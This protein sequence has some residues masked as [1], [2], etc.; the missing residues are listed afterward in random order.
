MIPQSLGTMAAHI[1]VNT[2]QMDVGIKMATS[3]LKNFSTSI[4]KAGLTTIAIGVTLGI[5]LA[6]AIKL[7]GKFDDEMRTVSAVTGST[8]DE[9]KLLTKQA[10]LLGR[11]TSF[12]VLEV[13][14]GMVTLGRAS[15]SFDFVQEAIPNILNLA[16][17]TGTELAR[18]AEFATATLNAFK[19]EASEM[20]R[21]TDTLTATANASAQTL[22]DLGESMKFAAPVAKAFGMTMEETA[23][24]IGTLANIGVKGSMAG[25]GLRM[26]MLQLV[27]SSNRNKLMDTLGVDVIDQ[28]TGGM[29]K[30]TV[31]L[32][33]MDKAMRSQGLGQ[34]DI[35]SIMSDVFGARAVTAGLTLGTTKFEALEAAIKN[36]S[37]TTERTAKK[38]DAGLGGAL[39]R[40]WSA[41]EGARLAV[42]EGLATGVDALAKAFTKVLGPLTAFLERNQWVVQAV[43]VVTVA[44]LTVGITLLT[45]SAGAWLASAAMAG[46]ATAIKVVGVALKF[47]AANPIIL[48]IIGIVALVAAIIHFLGT[49]DTFIE[50][51]K[52]IGIA[53]H[54]FILPAINSFLKFVKRI[55]DFVAPIFWKL[56]DVAKAAWGMLREIITMA[57]T[58]V[59]FVF[60]AVSEKIVRIWNWVWNTLG[61]IVQP[62]LSFLKP[63]IIGFLDK[64]E[65]AFKEWKLLIQIAVMKMVTFVVGAFWDLIHAIK[66]IPTWLTWMKDNWRDILQTIWN[67]LKTFAKNV[68]ENLKNLG[69]SIVRLFT[70]G[71]WKFKWTDLTKGFES[72]IK[73]FPDIIKRN[74]GPIE[75]ALKDTVKGLEKEL[76]DAYLK[77]IT[78]KA[79]EH[80][81]KVMNEA[82]VPIEEE[83]EEALPGRGIGTDRGI[84]LADLAEKG[85][86]DAYSA[87]V[88]VAN[89]N[90]RVEDNTKGIWDEVKKLNMDQKTKDTSKADTVDLGLVV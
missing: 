2:A 85:T 72:T 89:P 43:G 5:G 83:A 65:F 67:G 79:N 59:V 81:K 70:S 78:K 19:L 1:A 22:S 9:L 4:R 62:V 12:T 18:S 90:K 33:E 74:V 53:I 11:T 61:A 26:V 76:A 50:K 60:S 7:F 88:K 41:A 37:G 58:A 15:G 73:K 39:R 82:E 45:V 57:L 64:I 46:F 75:Q 47:L 8:T 21:V 10:K 49:G 31:I 63:L 86:A 13:A 35:L 54:K 44:L 27:K 80:I 71:K 36:M 24:A 34:A 48:I 25:T 40:L 87:I 55:K 29:K 6:S 17:A 32:G 38:M 23:L 30:L 66:Q 52:N 3:K 28:A 14:A 51:L 42:G 69:E 84:G 20:V 16:R 56:V 77:H 68:W